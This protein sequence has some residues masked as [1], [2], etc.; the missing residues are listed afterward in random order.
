MFT[1]L[2]TLTISDSDQFRGNLAPLQALTNLVSLNIINTSVSGTLDSILQLTRLTEVALANNELTGAISSAISQLTGLT[3]LLLNGNA[4]VSSLPSEIGRLTPLTLLVISS[5]RFNGSLPTTMSA[6]T[7]LSYLQLH[8]NRF[9][10]DLEPLV[11][12]TRLTELALYRNDFSVL[13]SGIGRLINLKRLFL[14]F[15]AFPSS[16]LPVWIGNLINLTTIQ[17]DNCGFSGSMDPLFGL[18][19]LTDLWVPG[20]FFT[21][22]PGDV[23]KL[24]NLQ[25][26][27]IFNNNITSSLPSQI[28]LLTSLRTLFVHR[29]NFT[30]SLP[31]AIGLLSRLND[32]F[33]YENSF[34]GDIG[35]LMPLTALTYL[36]IGDNR[37]QSRIPSE[38]DLLTALG[39]FYAY[40][41]D[42]QGTVP[43]TLNLL[44]NL[45]VLNFAGNRLEGTFPNIS[46]LTRL[47]E[48]RLNANNFST[49]P[50]LA[51]NTAL[52]L[53]YVHNNSLA[54]D[55][56]QLPTSITNSSLC[57]LQLA[58]DGNCMMCP[59]ATTTGPVRCTCVER[60]CVS[61]STL[62]ATSNLT[63][64]TD[65]T[66]TNNT[67]S[68]VP[69]SMTSTSPNST[70]WQTVSPTL[71]SPE[72]NDT[73]VIAGA[74]GG[75]VAALLMIALVFF[76]A[77]RAPTRGVDEQQPSDVAMKNDYGVLPPPRR[78]P[79]YNDVAD[80]HAL[81]NEYD[82]PGSLLN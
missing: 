75:I 33:L 52:T 68:T 30:G 61:M 70:M 69:S 54:G 15:N 74:V 34:S 37:F 32:A 39:T 58:I 1:G 16:T 9:D 40:L 31:M 43:T 76:L 24:A 57:L 80:V 63:I 11:N 49:I 4:L 79:E 28:G 59:M 51:S 8:I 38:I 5:N 22:L 77:L 14:S 7:Q 20:N 42:F 72:S 12:L 64:A 3:R 71:A 78:S 21:E 36:N 66:R 55:P 35:A 17:L 53:L 48:L 6:L 56:P 41:N 45:T 13:P 67:L 25:R 47:I 2:R 50:S 46:G 73:A 19:R 81:A 44:T 26:L 60:A 62:S 65:A 18:T 10:G 27:A 23:S 82:R 29:N